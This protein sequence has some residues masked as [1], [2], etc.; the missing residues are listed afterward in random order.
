MFLT[1]ALGLIADYDAETA[2]SVINRVWAALET[3]PQMKKK[4]QKAAAVEG[5][6]A[7][8]IEKAFRELTGFPLLPN[9]LAYAQG[10]AG[11]VAA[12]LTPNRTIIALFNSGFLDRVVEAYW[13]FK[14]DF[15][16]ARGRE[17]SQTLIDTHKAE[18]AMFK[19]K[20]HLRR[21]A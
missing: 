8:K 11:G 15:G 6:N 9:P 14:R 21:V 3:D 1:Y 10:F 13:G 20:K 7:E 18:F 17:L 19:T 4:I 5:S 16:D 12:S 2:G